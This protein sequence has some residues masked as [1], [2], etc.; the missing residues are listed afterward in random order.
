VILTYDDTREGIL[1]PD[2]PLRRGS[3]I[4]GNK[5]DQ[6]TAASGLQQKVWIF[7]VRN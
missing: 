6:N 5:L 2:N 7:K 3:P 4:Q 1:N